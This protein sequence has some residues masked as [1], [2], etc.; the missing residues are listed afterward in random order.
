MDERHDIGENFTG[1]TLGSLKVMKRFLRLPALVATVAAAASGALAQQASIRFE[2][3]G[4]LSQSA[5]NCIHQDRRGFLWIGTEDGLN[6]YDG[7][8]FTV[9]RRDPADPGS[10]AHNFVWAVEEDAEGGLWVGTEGGLHRRAPGSSAFA[11]LRH[12]AK[13]P[14]SVGADFVWALLRD[15]S[16]AMWVGTKGGGLSRYDAAKR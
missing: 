1:R 14:A 13:D 3:T 2:R 9:F 10:L 16:G 7:Y 15:R 8:S 12:D 5:V 6:R 4:G 11:R